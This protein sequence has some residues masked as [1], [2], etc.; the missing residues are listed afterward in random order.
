MVKL[1]SKFMMQ[2]LNM[3]SFKVSHL[4]LCIYSNTHPTS[5]PSTLV[6]SSLMIKLK[7]MVWIECTQ[8][9]MLLLFFLLL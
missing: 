5:L 2:L 4:G 3:A 8:L 1:K 7:T 6:V 9:V